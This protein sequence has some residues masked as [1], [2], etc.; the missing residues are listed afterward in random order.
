MT[1]CGSP[2]QKK[3]RYNR[4]PS[5]VKSAVSLGRWTVYTEVTLNSM[6]HWQGAEQE[7]RELGDLH[8]ASVGLSGALGTEEPGSSA[9]GAS[10]SP[11]ASLGA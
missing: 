11:Q 8:K 6:F 7:I 5:L 2:W 4:P 1:G 9:A 10:G 3:D